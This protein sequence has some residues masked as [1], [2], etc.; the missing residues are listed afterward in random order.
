MGKPVLL[1]PDGQPIRREVLTE[2]VAAAE[3]GSVR[4]ILGEHPSEGLT[5]IRLGRLLR[6][7]EDGDPTAY[8]ELAEDMEEKDLHYRSVLNTRKL[9]VA[10]LELQVEAV[11]DKAE[12]VRIA[13]EVRAWLA[14]PEIAG[15][16][17]GVL[18]AVGKGYSLSEIIW[19]T[20]EGQWRPARL[21]WRDPRWF[22]PSRVD[23]KTMMLRTNEGPQPLAPFKFIYHV[24]DSKSGVPVRGGLARVVAWAYLF[25]VFG[26]KSWVLF[27]E[28][29]GRPMRL[30]KYG[31]G[32][33]DKDKAT[34]L[35]AVRSIASDAAAIIPESMQMEL[36]EAKISGNVQLHESLVGYLD[37]QCS[38]AVLGQTGTTDTGQHVGTANA[39]EKVREDIEA[40]DAAQLAVTLMRDLVRP[41]VDLNFGPQKQYPLVRLYRPDAID[42]DKMMERLKTFVELGG[43]VEEA[44]I[45]DKLGIPDPDEGAL[46]LSASKAPPPEAPPAEEDLAIQSQEVPAVDRD[47]V[48]DLGDESLADWERQM[49]PM[50]DPI[51]QLLEECASLEEFQRR[52]PELVDR[53]DPAALAEGLARAAFFGR[54]A[55]ETDTDLG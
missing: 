16:L 35:R 41:A 47:G 21:E 50:V 6:A 5:P 28:A 12:D 23:G 34:L 7:A 26:L 27:A 30:G 24:H 40:W 46:L 9:Q 38:K 11:S 37:R 13:D 53:M 43:R 48:D 1:G 4:S 2:E 29:F 20:S 18:D 19:D 14:R 25:K 10:S 44:Y 32:A 22:E 15:E 8:L 3:L 42:L 45:R 51:Q 52:L 31:P 36:L 33:S 55:G 54:L 49:K 17:Y 39:H